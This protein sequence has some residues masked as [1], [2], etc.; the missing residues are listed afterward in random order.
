MELS[1]SMA[2]SISSSQSSSKRPLGD[3][4]LE[5]EPQLHHPKGLLSWRLDYR[6]WIYQLDYWYLVGSPNS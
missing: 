2:E 4:L 1:P 5:L 6:C 3:V